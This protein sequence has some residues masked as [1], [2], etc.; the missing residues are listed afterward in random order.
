ME[1]VIAKNKKG[2]HRYQHKANAPANI[3]YT[4]IFNELCNHE[5][6]AHER[7]DTNGREKKRIHVLKIENLKGV[8][9]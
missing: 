1:P 2:N 3:N 4:I 9:N 7:E 5:H 8:A 6:D